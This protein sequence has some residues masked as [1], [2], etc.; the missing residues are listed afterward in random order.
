MNSRR[1]PSSYS[2]SS[3]PLLSTYFSSC[4]FSVY[5]LSLSFSYSVSRHLLEHFSSGPSFF[6]WARKPVSPFLFS[7]FTVFFSS[8]PL[9]WDTSLVPS[10]WIS[11][12]LGLWLSFFLLWGFFP[13][14]D[15]LT[16][17]LLS[18]HSSD[19]LFCLNFISIR[20]FLESS[21]PSSL[22]YRHIRVFF[23]PAFVRSGLIYDSP[24]S[25]GHQP[26]H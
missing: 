15:L 12:Y 14:Y 4:D 2:F 17:F 10:Y 7:P 8:S 18:T 1:N 5:L 25:M 23:S 19:Y 6:E 3:S 9:Y 24:F 26:T 11:R 21:V 13:T 20:I 22:S 16:S